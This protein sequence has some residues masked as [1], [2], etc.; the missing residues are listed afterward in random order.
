MAYNEKFNKDDV[1]IRSM[2]VCLLAEM[3]KKLYIYN[4]DRCRRFTK[5][6]KK[7]ISNKEK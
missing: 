7:R 3:N 5:R 2:I 4:H 1:F 6:N